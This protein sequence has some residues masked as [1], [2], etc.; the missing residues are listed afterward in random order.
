MVG[1]KHNKA[2]E[3]GIGI[4]KSCFNN[5]ATFG[6]DGDIEPILYN[7]N[8][9]VPTNAEHFAVRVR[10]V[11]NAEDCLAKLSSF[12]GEY[13]KQNKH[14]TTRLDIDKSKKGCYIVHDQK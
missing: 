5:Q 1:T 11:I 9:E 8:Q 2:G 7:K 3:L 14:S 10:R 12:V 4:N 13:N 6:N